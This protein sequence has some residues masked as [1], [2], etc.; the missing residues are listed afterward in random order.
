MSLSGYLFAVDCRRCTVPFP[1]T[2]L[3]AYEMPL[4]AK[5]LAMSPPFFNDDY[6]HSSENTKS[7]IDMD[8]FVS[9]KNFCLRL[10][11]NDADIESSH[12]R[13][14]SLLRTKSRMAEDLDRLG[15]GNIN[16]RSLLRCTIESGRDMA[17]PPH[18]RVQCM[19]R[20]SLSFP[21]HHVPS[22]SFSG[23]LSLERFG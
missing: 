13:K 22:E 21:I 23:F 3:Q 16:D 19:L 15:I 11:R 7:V 2:T 20:S 4:K 8:K 5:A 9:S 12:C 6:F 14:S 17:I 18:E 1:K 10:P